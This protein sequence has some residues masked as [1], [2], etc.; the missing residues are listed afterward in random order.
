MMDRRAFIASLAAAGATAAAAKA[1]WTRRKAEGRAPS[2]K[3]NATLTFRDKDH[4]VLATAPVTV[5]GTMKQGRIEPFDADI[6][7]HGKVDHAVLTVP[8]LTLLTL[9]VGLMGD[10]KVTTE[11]WYLGDILSIESLQWDVAEVLEQPLDHHEWLR[12]N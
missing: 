4:N 3:T 10:I 6:I 5:H 9:S 1:D 8:N 2:P 12:T 11:Y 7:A